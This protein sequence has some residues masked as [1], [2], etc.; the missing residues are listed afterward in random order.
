MKY[1][2]QEIEIIKRAVKDY[3]LLEKEINKRID[4]N[5]NISDLYDYLRHLAS[6]D[7]ISYEDN[8]KDYSYIDFNYCDMVCII[9]EDVSHNNKLHLSKNIELWNDKELYVINED[10]NI[11]E[12]KKLV[13]SEEI[14]Y[15]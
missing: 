8:Y 7:V 14:D 4:N 3:D 11:D 13:E 9:C 12:L 1:N 10:V 6:C 5:Y 15:E 2:K